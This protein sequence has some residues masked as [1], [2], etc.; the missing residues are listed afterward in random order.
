AS[1]L[2]PSVREIGTSWRQHAPQPLRQEIG[3][4][5]SALCASAAATTAFTSP[6]SA[7]TTSAAGTGAAGTVI[8]WAICSSPTVRRKVAVTR[9]ESTIDRYSPVM[10]LGDARTLQGSHY[11]KRQRHP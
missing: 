11:G 6:C 5:M 8:G 3:L 7:G 1:T 9:P 4:P 10:D 2:S